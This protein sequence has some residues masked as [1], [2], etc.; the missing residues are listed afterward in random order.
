MNVVDLTFMYQ[1]QNVNPPTRHSNPLDAFA[2]QVYTHLIH[3]QVDGSAETFRQALY[4]KIHVNLS[5]SLSRMA[6][7][8]LICQIKRHCN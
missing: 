5:E 7:H 3:P 8:Y 6:E 4:T 2:S 1:E